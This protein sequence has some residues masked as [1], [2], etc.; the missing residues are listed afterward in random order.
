RG[1][2]FMGRGPAA[3]ATMTDYVRRLRA[4]L[5][6][7]Y[8]L[9]VTI[10]DPF[11]EHLTNREYPYRAIAAGASVLQPMVY[12]GALA[13]CAQF[14]AVRPELVRDAIRASYRA[15]LHEANRVM[16]IDVG[17]Q[18]IPLGAAAPPSPEEIT[19]SLDAARAQGAIGEA[20]FDWNGTRASQWNAI[21]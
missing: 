4:A 19:A 1:E 7:R 21:A 5:G 12:W 6:P 17:G 18:T 20:F 16:P 9:T 14:C 2:E 10:E 3:Y 15:T 8:P 13:R 11:I